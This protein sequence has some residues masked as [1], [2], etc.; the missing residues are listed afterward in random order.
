M[1]LSAIV[2]D[3]A[4]VEDVMFIPH[5]Q[6]GWKEHLLTVGKV[7]KN[8]LRSAKMKR[9]TQLRCF[10]KKH[11]S[12]VKALAIS[13]ASIC[14]CVLRNLLLFDQVLLCLLLPC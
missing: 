6:R 13:H 1:S 12:C 14:L 10:T 7:Q 3:V 11:L 2:V 4:A 9:H 8:Q 5:D